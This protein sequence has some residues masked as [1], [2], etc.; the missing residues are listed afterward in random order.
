MPCNA[1]WLG[2]G[3]HLLSPDTVYGLP[4]GWALYI[5]PVSDTLTVRYEVGVCP[6]DTGAVVRSLLPGDRIKLSA[7]DTLY[8]QV[9]ADPSSPPQGGVT[10]EGSLCVYAFRAQCIGGGWEPATPPDTLDYT[11]WTVWEAIRASCICNTTYVPEECICPNVDVDGGDVAA[12]A[13]ETLRVCR[14]EGLWIALAPYQPV[15]ACPGG[16]CATWPRG[17]MYATL[18]YQAPGGVPQVLDSCTL[19][20]LANALYCNQPISCRGGT[21]YSYDVVGGRP[22]FWLSPCPAPGR[23]WGIPYW[24]GVGN[25]GSGTVVEV[26]DTRVAWQ[27]SLPGSA[28]GGDT[29]RLCAV[30]G[31]VSYLSTYTW[32]IGGQS[33]TLP[34]PAPQGGDSAVVC[35]TLTMPPTGD[36]TVSLSL[37]YNSTLI[38]PGCCTAP[39]F[40]DGSTCSSCFSVS[41]TIRQATRVCTLTAAPDS[42]C[43]GTQP[44]V[45][46]LQG[47]NC[48]FPADVVYLWQPGDG[49]T[50][51]TATPTFS[52]TYGAAG[53]YTAQV[54]ACPPGTTTPNPSCYCQASRTVRVISPVCA[55]SAT[56]DTV[57]AGRQ[58]VTFTLQLSRCPAPTGTVYFWQPGDGQ[59]YNTGTSASFSY[60]YG[61]AGTY[62]VQAWAC[63]PGTPAPNA[64]CYCQAS[65]TVHVVTP[66]QVTLQGVSYM[67]WDTTPRR[68]VV[69]GW[70]PGDQILWQLF[71]GGGSPTYTLN[72]DTLTVLNWGGSTSCIVQAT[73][74]RGPCVV[75]VRRTVAKGTLNLA[76]QG[77]SPT[78]CRPGEYWVIGVPPA[79]QVTWIVP[80]GVSYTLGGTN[81]ANPL[82]LVQ[83][84]G[85]YTG[86]AVRICAVV[87]GLWGC[88]D[89]VCLDIAACCGDPA[90]P[91]TLIRPTRVS[92]LLQSDPQA[93]Q[94]KTYYVNDTLYVDKA[95]TW[96]NVQMYFGPYGLV[97]V[98]PGVELTIRTERGGCDCARGGPYWSRLE[99]CQKR[100]PGIYAQAGSRVR[101]EGEVNG[102]P[103][104]FPVWVIGADTGVW[105]EGRAYWRVSGAV[106]NRCGVGLFWKARSGEETV[107][108]ACIL[109]NA[110][111]TW[112]D[113]VWVQGNPSSCFYVDMGTRRRWNLTRPPISVDP[114]TKRVQATVGVWV[115]SGDSL[116][117]QDDQ[118]IFRGLHY[119]IVGEGATIEAIKPR[120]ERL[121][122]ESCLIVRS[123]SLRAQ[124]GV[125][126]LSLPGKTPI[127]ECPQPFD[128]PPGTGV[129]S[130]WIEMDFRRFLR[131]R[132]SQFD[133]VYVGVQAVGRYGLSFSLAEVGQNTF[134]QGSV[135]ILLSDIGNRGVSNRSFSLSITQNVISQYSRGIVLMRSANVDG[136]IANNQILITP[137]SSLEGIWISER[138]IYLK[139][140]PTLTIQG[141]LLSGYRTG[142]LASASDGPIYIKQNQIIT[143]AFV[144]ASGVALQKPTSP[145]LYQLCQNTLIGASLPA[146]PICDVRNPAAIRSLDF[147]AIQLQVYCNTSQGYRWGYHFRDRVSATP[148]VD[149]RRNTL[150]HELHFFYEGNRGVLKIGDSTVASGSIYLPA[151]PK[152]TVW[153]GGDIISKIEVFE[154]R[155]G[156]SIQVRDSSCKLGAYSFVVRRAPALCVGV[157]R[158]LCG[159]VPLFPPGPP[160]PDTSRSARRAYARWA[161]F[162]ELVKTPDTTWRQ[163]SATWAFFQ[164]VEASPMGQ[165]ELAYHSYRAGD[166]TALSLS[167]VLPTTQPMEEA[168]QTALGLIDKAERT[169]LDAADVATLWQIAYGC[170]D[171]VG[172]AAYL[173]QELL[174]WLGADTVFLPSPCSANEASR[175][176][177]P[178]SQEVAEGELR[179]PRKPYL[180]ERVPYRPIEERRPTTPNPSDTTGPGPRPMYLHLLPNPAE[181]SVTIYYGELP[182]SEGLLEIYDSQ[183]RRV[184][185]REIEGREGYQ[186]LNVVHWSRGIYQVI[187]RSGRAVRRENLWIY[188]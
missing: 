140:L 186:R 171:S 179:E 124:L 70:Q 158:G 49:Q 152:P 76:I 52:Y 156:V 119:G 125:R 108:S 188:P 55:L 164:Q 72:Y 92:S 63:P 117:I 105:A 40:R 162:R 81:P 29:V 16:S 145:L 38:C 163:D 148:P 25:V 91:T 64:S 123:D 102:S 17:C 167:Q 181:L 69:S 19:G 106:F 147:N 170:P 96:L 141:N 75:T 83:G 48:A 132:E 57:C 61:M 58:P 8:V 62:T 131:I 139:P 68:F 13:A 133:T 90:A 115:R 36:L 138:S 182:E 185:W 118:V 41:H 10:F 161:T 27:G 74:Q 168:F 94:C 174:R 32:T 103:Q 43:V 183:G 175:L 146:L 88:S 28:C 166:P 80:A 93:F 128:C 114:L 144:G 137:R 111:F 20:G 50:Y 99:P 84:W 95:V 160:R 7:E 85:P 37:T 172:P 122:G 26:V 60:T 18:Y 54:W 101:I 1:V 155:P 15:H 65:T 110:L 180:F 112:V 42:V 142:I 100:W 51:S 130:Q 173:A 151:A 5:G 33:F 46:S 157:A 107:L 12:C 98:E 184:F 6:L 31:G 113:S 143:P 67:C 35:T 77:T 135:A 86:Q 127:I 89:T 9:E 2:P 109:K 39:A 71:C 104:W 82:L 30:I 154:Q 149:F 73:V 3:T 34:A 4:P 116:S 66:P 126:Q 169:F 187:L 178:D 153:V 150:N 165:L 79:T 45:F 136:A 129:C 97:W 134:R 159:T 11:T 177:P 87:T 120:Y 47:G 176:A 56:P 59:T 53:T 121:D 44:V 23:Y 22:F 78:T 14:S 24:I 21:A